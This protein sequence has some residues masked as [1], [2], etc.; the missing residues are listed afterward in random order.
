MRITST[1]ANIMAVGQSSIRTR[2]GVRYDTYLGVVRIT[3]FA[4]V[5]SGAGGGPGPADSDEREE[6]V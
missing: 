1:A 5:R 2:E 3:R 6:C 4:G